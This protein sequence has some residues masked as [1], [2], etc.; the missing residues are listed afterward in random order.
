MILLSPQN[1]PKVVPILYLVKIIVKS[2][3]WDVRMEADVEGK[4]IQSESVHQGNMTLNALL[5][6]SKIIHIFFSKKLHFLSSAQRRDRNII[7]INRERTENVLGNQCALI[8]FTSRPSLNPLNLENKEGRDVC[9]I[10]RQCTSLQ[11]EERRDRI[12]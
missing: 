8:L 7:T 10:Y 2:P 5:G 1:F 6:N 3:R 12:K 4:M 11:V 9:S